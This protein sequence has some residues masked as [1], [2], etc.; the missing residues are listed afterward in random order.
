MATA[1]K[2]TKF[3]KKPFDRTTLPKPVHEQPNA[4]NVQGADGLMRPNP[5]KSDPKEILGIDKLRAGNVLTDPGAALLGDNARDHAK[6]TGSKKAAASTKD[7]TAAADKKAADEAKKQKEVA[8][9]AS[10]K[11]AG[12]AKKQQDDADAKNKEKDEKP[13]V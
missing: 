11:S 12:D 5:G 9:L 6:E 13:T 1:T 8:D 4:P 7:A 3:V 10:K 2:D